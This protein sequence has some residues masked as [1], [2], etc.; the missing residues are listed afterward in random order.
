MQDT[1][2][3]PINA[4]DVAALRVLNMDTSVRGILAVLADTGFLR[5]DRTPT[6]ERWFADKTAELP[7]GMVGGLWV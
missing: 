2:G 7:A 3:A 1:P 5:E 6:I 4:S